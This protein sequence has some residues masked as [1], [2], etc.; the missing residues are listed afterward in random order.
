MT[1]SRNSAF[2]TPHSAFT[3][4]ELLVVITIIGILAALLLV[5]ATGALKT[6]RR[7]AIKADIDNLS[8]AVEVYKNDVGGGSYPP[9]CMTGD[10]GNPWNGTRS[11]ADNIYNNTT[12]LNDLRR[13]MKKVSPRHR[14]PENL[15]DRIAGEDET[16]SNPAAGPGLRGGMSA[17]EALVFW[18]GGFSSDPTAPITG[19]GGLSY[20]KADLGVNGG[21]EGRSNIGIFDVGRMGPRD[22]DDNFIGRFLEYDINGTIWRINFWQY[23]PSKSVKPFVYF[24][25][26]RQAPLDQSLSAY[27]PGDTVDLNAAKDIIYPILLVPAGAT[28]PQYANKEKFQILH[29]GVDDE[30]GNMSVFAPRYGGVTPNANFLSYP[31]GPF[32]GEIADTVVNFSTGTLEDSQE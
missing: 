21:L 24:D 15:L 30:W 13:H 8:Q 23:Y 4:V 9:S 20:K 27:D 25:A 16:N 22:E 11:N 32:T 26:S 7:T 5:A 28:V 2:R 1:T 14:E 17:A 10:A 12:V 3:L 18:L 31:A 6:A 29:A 19:A